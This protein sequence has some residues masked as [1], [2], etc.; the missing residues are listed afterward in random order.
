MKD[1][2]YWSNIPTTNRNLIKNFLPVHPDT[3]TIMKR[4]KTRMEIARLFALHKNAITKFQKQL[5]GGVL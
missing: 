3:A 2:L 1:F 4:K 5:P